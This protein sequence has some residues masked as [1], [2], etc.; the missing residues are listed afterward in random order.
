[1]GG[2]GGERRVL[3]VYVLA[4]SGLRQV[5]RQ[6]LQVHQQ[7]TGERQGKAVICTC[8][9][10]GW[11]GGQFLAVTVVNRRFRRAEQSLSRQGGGSGVLAA[12]LDAS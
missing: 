3:C 5:E 10:L 9:F 11:V 7:D 12:A 8:T 1:V 2:G 6:E 4:C